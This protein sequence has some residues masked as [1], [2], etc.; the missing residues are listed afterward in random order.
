MVDPKAPQNWTK[1]FSSKEM[2]ISKSP[3]KILTRYFEKPKEIW[4]FISPVE[5]EFL[6]ENPREI[7]KKIFSKDFFFYSK[8]FEEKK[9]NFMNLFW[10]ILIQ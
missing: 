1:P 7:A 8:R 3:Q 6:Y 2:R 9:R 4:E 5:I 10:L